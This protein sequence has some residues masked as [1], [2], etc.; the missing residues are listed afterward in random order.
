M[1]PCRQISRPSIRVFTYPSVPQCSEHACLEPKNVSSCFW[2]FVRL[3]V[4]PFPILFNAHIFGTISLTA[5]RY[6]LKLILTS[7]LLLTSNYYWKICTTQLSY[8]S[9]N[10][11][12]PFY[13]PLKLCC[14]KV[15]TPL[16]PSR[17]PGVWCHLR[18]LTQ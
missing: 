4:R 5:P 7:L 8:E 11:K 17:P 13:L 3:K 14:K 1:D 15:L 6:W 12:L 2:K 9:H 18:M 16:H 10:Q